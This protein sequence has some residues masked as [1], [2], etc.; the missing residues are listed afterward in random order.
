MDFK[1]GEKVKVKKDFRCKYGSTSDMRNLEGEIVTIKSI[2]DDND[3]YLEESDC[4][5]DKGCFEKLLKPTKEELL[6]MSKGTKI[7]TNAIDGYENSFVFDG[8][9][10]SNIEYS[11]EDYEIND[12]LTLDLS[13]DDYGTKILEV[14]KPTYATIYSMKEEKIEMTVSQI[15][16]EL[17]H[18]VKIVKEEN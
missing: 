3:I 4:H 6:K 8:D 5:W 16:K 2:E 10:F 14:L 17:G 12:D 7:I 9:S 15:E 18:G 11:I 13:D 1:V